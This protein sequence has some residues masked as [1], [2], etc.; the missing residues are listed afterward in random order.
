MSSHTIPVLVGAGAVS[1]CLDDPAVALEAWQLM[2]EATRR[3]AADAG[4]PAL[5]S[6][7]DA[8]RVP[9]GMWGYADPG[10]M[11]AKAVG[12][13]DARS[14]LADI[15][16]LQTTLLADAC[17]A[18]QLGH[19][20]IAVV[21]GGEARY[22]YLLGEKSGSP[23]FETPQ[24]DAPDVTLRPEA[25]LWSAAEWEHGLGMPVNSYAVME[26]AL[27]HAEG[28]GMAEHRAEVGNL[29]AG[30]S[31]V[32]ARNPE[33]WYREAMTGDEIAQASGSNRMLA[34]PYAKW[35][36]SQWNVDQAAALILCSEAVAD[37]LGIPAEKRIYPLAITES[38]HMVPLSARRELHR[39]PGY[40]LAGERALE[41]A[42]LTMDDIRHFE[43]YSCFPVAVRVQVRELGIPPG[44]PL[45]VTGG[46]TFAGGPLNNFVY[47]ALVAMVHALRTHPGAG[48][49]TAVSG[50]LTKQGV[51]LWSTQRPAQG[52]AFAEVTGEVREA[53]G[54]CEVVEKATGPATIAGYTV[55]FDKAGQPVRGVVVADLPDGRRTVAHSDD[56]VL[57]QA[58]T[59]TEFCARDITLSE[60]NLFSA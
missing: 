28:Q 58:M 34:F 17:E 46:M 36:T 16:I 57:A 43:I 49:V 15:G 51:S 10:R 31:H 25:E 42:G 35:H 30:F 44:R 8:M 21:L 26:N 53:M 24:S 38:N 4:A 39:C 5:L 55:L 54:V 18:I 9:K 11:V 50:L 60:G 19:E 33:A 56:P 59:E 47:Q 37:E 3:A 40:A 23:A 32:A 13:P 6:R 14:I 12:S 2:E 41:L 20:K 7:I 52:F 27:R 45:T 1:Q 48:L 29:W 22:R